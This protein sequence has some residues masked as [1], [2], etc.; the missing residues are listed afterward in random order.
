MM[1]IKKIILCTFIISFIISLSGCVEQNAITTG[2]SFDNIEFE[3]DIV[4]LN[5]AKLDFIKDDEEFGGVRSVILNYKLHNPNKRVV[6]VEVDVIF[7]D[8]FDRELYSKE[9]YTIN[10]PAMYT[11]GANTVEFNQDQ[12]NEVEYVKITAYEKIE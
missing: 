7:Y 1:E 5:N 12:A 4:E 8:E 10:L 3:S 11:E 6:T 2:Q 9:D